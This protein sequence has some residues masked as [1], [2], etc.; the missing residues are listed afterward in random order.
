MAGVI[1]SPDKIPSIDNIRSEKKN[2]KRKKNVK[3]AYSGGLTLI[4]RISIHGFLGIIPSG[5][6]FPLMISITEYL[7]SFGNIRLFHWS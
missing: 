3:V 5:E 2:L 7:N 1:I 6:T 4:L